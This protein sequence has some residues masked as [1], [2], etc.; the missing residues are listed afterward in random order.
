MTRLTALW[1][2]NVDATGSTDF[3]LPHVVPNMAG[4]RGALGVGL[5]QQPLRGVRP[6]G[7]SVV[8]FSDPLLL[9][10]YKTCGHR[11]PWTLEGNSS[12]PRSAAGENPVYSQFGGA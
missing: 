4:L 11:A 7:G 8:I 6:T 2:Q 10:H 9:W 5:L 1:S 12:V 3:L